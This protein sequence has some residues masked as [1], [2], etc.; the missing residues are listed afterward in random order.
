MLYPMHT[1][2]RSFAALTI[3]IGL[4]TGFLHAKEGMD[5]GKVSLHYLAPKSVDFVKLL[6]APPKPETDEAKQEMEVV[7]RVQESRTPAEVARAESEA[8]LTMAAFTQVVGKWFTAENLPLTAKLIKAAE[9]DSKVFSAAAKDHFGRKRPPNDARVKPTIHGE[10]EPSYPSGHATRGMLFGLIL[11]ELDPE[12]R[13][14][15]MDRAREIGWDRVIAGVHFPSDLVAGRVLGQAI[16]QGM[17]SNPSF[18]KDLEAA[19]AEFIAAKM[20]AAR[21]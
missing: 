9:A 4:S 13:D 8:K 12:Q 16:F 3:L 1:R 7:L 10:D 14:A 11:A 19:K 2:L 5:S 18:R 6:P 17:S 20:K 21:E 15:L